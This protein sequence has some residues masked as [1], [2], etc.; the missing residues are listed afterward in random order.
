M[1]RDHAVS[2]RVCG[3]LTGHAIAE[4]RAALDPL[5]IVIATDGAFNEKAIR[6]S[7]GGAIESVHRSKDFCRVS[8]AMQP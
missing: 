5:W 4:Y 2:C 1:I 6:D 7:V 8:E 3:T